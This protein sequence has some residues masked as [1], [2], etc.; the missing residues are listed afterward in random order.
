MMMRR[1]LCCGYPNYARRA[2]GG[3]RSGS[4]RKNLEHFNFEII[5]SAFLQATP[6]PALNSANKL[7]L[8]LRGGRPLSR[9]PEHFQSENALIARR[10][11][12]EQARFAARPDGR[13]KGMVFS[14]R[15]LPAERN[16]QRKGARGGRIFLRP[17][18]GDAPASPEAVG[19]ARSKAASPPPRIQKICSLNILK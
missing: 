8:R 13:L 16:T 10:E 18:R 1:A 4:R 6:A 9:S 5:H 19:F 15:F 11:A 12:R 3:F 14:V 7:R 2:R 17:P